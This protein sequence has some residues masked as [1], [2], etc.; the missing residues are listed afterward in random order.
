MLLMNHFFAVI[1]INQVNVN[2][3]TFMWALISRRSVH[4]A[5]ARLSC[6]GIDKDVSVVNWCDLKRKPLFIA[7]IITTKTWCISSKLQGNCANFVETEQ[8]VEYLNDK[9][10]FVQIRGS[11]PLYWSQTPNC[12]YKPA[13]NIDLSKEH[14]S[15]AIKHAESLLKTYGRHIYINLVSLVCAFSF[16]TWHK[17]ILKVNCSFIYRLIIVVEDCC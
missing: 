10:S 16:Q 6:R 13:I 7:I 14:L 9:L 8:I 3:S 4:R 2:N 11:I 5:G 17:I 1:S 15:A 12:R